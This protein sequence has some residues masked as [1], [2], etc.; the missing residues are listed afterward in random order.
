MNNFENLIKTLSSRERRRTHKT[1]LITWI[2]KPTGKKAFSRGQKRKT[3]KVIFS[4]GK[5]RQAIEAMKSQKLLCCFWRYFIVDFIFYSIM[6]ELN[7]H[8]LNWIQQKRKTNFEF[9]GFMSKQK[10]VEY[11]A[12]K[13][14][15]FL[16]FFSEMKNSCELFCN[17]N[18]GAHKERLTCLSARF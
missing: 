8:S 14:Y 1:W 11:R 18:S 6:Q 13:M 7:K 9:S 3:R 5:I 2:Y 10:K 12:R 16:F 4:T 15:F 17:S